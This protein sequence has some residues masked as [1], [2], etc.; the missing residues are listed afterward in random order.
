MKRI[1]LILTAAFLAAFS[2]SGEEQFPRIKSLE[3]DFTQLRHVQMLDEVLSIEGHLKYVA[4]DHLE[5]TYGAPRNCKFTMDGGKVTME[6]LQG[7]EIADPGQKK[8]FREIARMM[9]GSIA[10]KEMPKDMHQM[11][12]S[13][14][15]TLDPASSVASRVEIEELSG[16]ST[17]L[18]FHNPVIER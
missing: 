5:W 1:L 15:I 4:P 6:D 17:V 7:N 16:D 13:V 10:G 11:A 9:L 8:V 18:I 3:C 12:S 14:N 2:A